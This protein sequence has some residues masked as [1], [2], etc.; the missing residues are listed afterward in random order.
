M[1]FEGLSLDDATVLLDVDRGLVRKA[2]VF[3]LEGAHA[4][5]RRDAGGGA[6]LTAFCP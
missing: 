3:A 1:L 5:S 4:E 2:Q 6:C